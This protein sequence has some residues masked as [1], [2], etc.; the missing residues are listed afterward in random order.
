VLAEEV[1][2]AAMLGDDVWGTKALLDLRPC[3]EAQCFCYELNIKVDSYVHLCY[4]A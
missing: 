3:S 4:G 1:W 2:Q